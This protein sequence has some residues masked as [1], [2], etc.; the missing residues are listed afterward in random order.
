MQERRPG[1][2]V[3]GGGGG[4]HWPL[5][6]GQQRERAGAWRLAARV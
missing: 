2:V 1:S 4:G 5:L 3:A 6:P